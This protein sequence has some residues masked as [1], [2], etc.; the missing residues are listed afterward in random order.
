[1]EVTARQL[2]QKAILP[3]SSP[4]DIFQKTAS[5]FRLTFPQQCAR[6]V[7]LAF[8]IG[9]FSRFLFVC[10]RILD[11]TQGR[12]LLHEFT[13]LTGVK[14]LLARMHATLACDRLPTRNGFHLRNFFKGFQQRPSIHVLANRKIKKR[15]NSRRDID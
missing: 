11:V 10:A 1:M 5:R 12:E 2:V 3:R 14:L 13:S 4:D 9:G 15:E 7:V 8:D 6:D